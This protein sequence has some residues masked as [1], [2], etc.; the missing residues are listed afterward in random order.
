MVVVQSGRH[1]LAGFVM[2]I[3]EQIG[4][5]DVIAA[6]VD[7]FYERVL[8]D[9]D[10]A[11]SFTHIDIDRL[12][13]HQRAFLTVALDGPQTYDGRSLM[14]AH[15][16]LGITSQ[17][18]DRSVRHLVATFVG[19]HVDREIVAEVATRLELLRPQIV[20]RQVRAS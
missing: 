3:F 16:G 15:S 14:E 4:G 19:M 12:K 18:F 9:A 8:D 5:G 20:E 17:Q 11:P 6:A 2:T 1:G 10:L 7:E 13:A